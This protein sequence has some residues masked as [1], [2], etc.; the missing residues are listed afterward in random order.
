MYL[1]R[2][3]QLINKTNQFN[4]TTRRY[5][6]AEVEAI[7]QDPRFVTLYGRLA[8]KFGDNGLVSVLI[9]RIVDDALDI[10]FG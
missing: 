3:T 10:D 7:A 1:E 5:T 8:D 4:L 2:I 6:T 9:G